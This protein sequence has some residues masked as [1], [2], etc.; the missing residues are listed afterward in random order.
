MKTGLN[1]ALVILFLALAA[2]CGGP[3]AAPVPETAPAQQP[4]QE[5]LPAP[6]AVPQAATEN[7]AAPTSPTAPPV[8]EPTD[9]S[10]LAPTTQ[11]STPPATV[12][13][14]DG[15]EPADS[16]PLF[17]NL[18]PATLTNATGLYASPNRGDLI[19][20]VP[21]PAGQTVYV[22]GRNASSSHLR[23]VWNTGVGWVPT[24]FT[25]FNGAKAKMAA[26]PVFTANH[27]AARFR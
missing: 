7:G 13:Y 9:A 19:V 15:T 21:I 18:P 16:A 6:T 10:V 3:S 1:V 8:Q 23:V 17:Y 2:A 4:A 27:R 14:Q 24:S 25:D 11:E 20:E 22:M 12:P 5:A 26:L